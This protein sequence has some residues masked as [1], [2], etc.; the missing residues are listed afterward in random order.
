VERRLAAIMFVDIVGYTALMAE[1]EAN[2]L[3]A[4]ERHRA[5]VRPLVE[6]YHG[7]AIEARG[8]ESLAVFPTA[9]DAVN[10]ALAI[11][12]ALAGGGEHRVHIGIHMGDLV[13]ERGEVSG[14]AVNI[15]ARIRS[16]AESGVC[17]SGEVYHS[18]RNQPNIEARP[19]GEQEL[20]NVGRPVALFAI[21]GAAAAPSATPT[22]R[23]PAGERGPIRSLAVL[24]LENLSGDPNQEYFADGMTE[25]LIGDLGNL[26]ALRVISR[27]SVMQYKGVRKPLPEI[28]AELGVD[29]LLEGTVIREGDCVRITAQLID[30][31]TDA[32]LWSERYDRDL[33]GILDLQSEVARAVARRIELELT[34]AE[35][36]RLASRQRVDPAAHDTLLRGIH[37]V[38]RVTIESTRKAIASFE[39]A[40][41]ARSRL[42]ASTRLAGNRM[43]HAEPVS[44]RRSAP[45]RDAKGEVRD[46]PGVGAQRFAR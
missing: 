12:E 9:L 20:R 31:R 4:R 7:E 34:P 36:A 43:V 6:K 24:P 13:V 11:E 29:A 14:D 1:R 28:A 44:G 46:T 22:R 21:R 26:R 3:R 8:D 23:A 38:G 10:C 25:T 27:T 32:H 19:L 33:R 45:R 39:R 17:V 40:N 30:G 37:R 41:H 18:V 16:F 35:A 15:A 5:L 2:G 42:R